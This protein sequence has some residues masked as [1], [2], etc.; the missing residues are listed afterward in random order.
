MKKIC[1]SVKG[2][3]NRNQKNLQF[4]PFSCPYHKGFLSIRQEKKAAAGFCRSRC[5]LLPE[6]L[7]V[8]ALIH[9]E[10]C[11]VGT[12]QDLVQGAVVL[13]LTVIS[14]LL[15]GTFD[16]LVCVT[17]HSNF[18]LLFIVSSS[19][20]GLFGN[21]AGKY[22]QGCICAIFMIWLKKEI[23]GGMDDGEDCSLCIVCG[24]CESGP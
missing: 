1:T 19:M 3:F 21:Y 5:L 13:V 6:R 23:E 11:L 17:I 7:A 2:F 14:T 4:F 22:F 16:T 18:L 15:D 24:L 12:H 10:I 20:C 8:S 9:R